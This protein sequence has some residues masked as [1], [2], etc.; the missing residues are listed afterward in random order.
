MRLIGLMSRPVYAMIT[1]SQARSELPSFVRDEG[2]DSATPCHSGMARFSVG[3]GVLSITIPHAAHRDRMGFRLNP[4][5]ALK[6]WVQES[7][8]VELPID[9]SE[10]L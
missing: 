8:A 5:E 6:M 7:Q 3:Q 2:N 10:G 4:F 9:V 1:P